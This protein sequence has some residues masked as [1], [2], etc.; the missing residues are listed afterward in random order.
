MIQSTG[1]SDFVTTA[2]VML[3]FATGLTLTFDDFV[4]IVRYPLAI[5]AGLIGQQIL[6]PLVAFMIAF[7]LELPAAIAIGLII[8]AACPGATTSNA[9]SFMVVPAGWFQQTLSRCRMSWE[10][11][12]WRPLH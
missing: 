11:Q 5:A 8:L 9:V 2:Q 1:L 12:L 3:M 10:K 4:R 7:A 6:L